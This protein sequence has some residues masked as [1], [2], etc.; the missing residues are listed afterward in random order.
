MGKFNGFFVFT[1]LLLI[2]GGGCFEI[3]E[4]KANIP[5]NV[6][7][8]NVS[9]SG[10]AACDCSADDMSKRVF[11][12]IELNVVEPPRLRKTIDDL[13]S[14][15]L[16][17]FLLNVLFIVDDTKKSGEKKGGF[18]QL[19]LTVG[20]GWRTPV[21]ADELFWTSEKEVDELCLVD[22]DLNQKVDVTSFDAA[23]CTFVNSDLKTLYFHMG[24]KGNP[25]MCAPLLKQPNATPLH[26]LRVTFRLNEDCTELKDGFLSGCIPISD[27]NK[28]CMCG[29]TGV[30]VR[31]GNEADE[32][33]PDEMGED[34][35][36]TWPL[37]DSQ[38]KALLTYCVNAC[39]KATD[40]SWSSYRALMEF[41]SDEPTCETQS[42]EPGYRLTARFKA[43]EVTKQYSSDQTVCEEN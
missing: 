9:T 5:E 35:D 37:S 3:V 8:D 7:T 24:H 17:N 14:H 11:R 1:T 21:E 12:F 27:A 40:S 30:C 10:E 38:E 22:D 42:G 19:S 20:P 31:D 33:F 39:G 29:T 25:L 41:G 34:G 32:P 6:E 43:E 18:S 13:W 4:P 2:V 15:E 16:N 28:M 36:E 23:E 26:D